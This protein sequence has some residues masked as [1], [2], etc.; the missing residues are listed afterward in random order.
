MFKFQGGE[1]K[2]VA[3]DQTCCLP[4]NYN[5]ILSFLLPP[6]FQNIPKSGNTWGVRSHNFY[7]IL[8]KF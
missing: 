7:I 4:T 5:V 2:R 6:E 1:K 3:T 8:L